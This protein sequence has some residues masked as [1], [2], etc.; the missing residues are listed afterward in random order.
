MIAWNPAF[1]AAYESPWCLLQKL[2][3]LNQASPADLMRQLTR[4][5]IPKAPISLS[6]WSFGH[7]RWLAPQEGVVTGLHADGEIGGFAGLVESLSVRSGD[8]IAGRPAERI[9]LTDRVRICPACIRVGYHS[10]VHQLSGLARCPIH[11][12]ALR[13][14][15]PQCSHSMPPFAL[16]RSPCGFV[17]DGCHQSW[18]R[19]DQ[20]IGAVPPQT[21][22]L[23][24]ATIGAIVW[25]LRDVARADCEFDAWAWAGW[26][27]GGWLRVRTPGPTVGVRCGDALIWFLDRIKAFPLK[28]SLLGPEPAGL[29]LRRQP[30]FL[31]LDQACLRTDFQGLTYDVIVEGAIQYVQNYVVKHHARCLRDSWVAV[32]SWDDT[33]PLL[34]FEEGS[35]PLAQAFIVWKNRVLRWRR[36]NRNWLLTE[37]PLT[38]SARIAESTAVEFWNNLMSSLNACVQATFLMTAFHLAGNKRSAAAV[39]KTMLCD[40]FSPW[41][42]NVGGPRFKCRRGGERALQFALQDSELLGR[43]NEHSY[44]S[45]F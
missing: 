13:D 5:R 28:T 34:D 18:L 36:I 25:W 8:S 20:V 2:S 29:C 24:E 22:E 15:C 43:C 26:S 27:N 6:S 39:A 44:G 45:V 19:D 23:E 11:D 12:L 41:L 4:G 37:A 1:A 30:A 14:T 40:E 21:R 9:I 3:W 38:R 10:T 17:C 31:E 7:A 35:C 16:V 33:G 32:A 42:R